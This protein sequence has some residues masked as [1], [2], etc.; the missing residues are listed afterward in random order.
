MQFVIEEFAVTN[1]E[2]ATVIAT[3]TTRL[4]KYNSAFLTL[5]AEHETDVVPA[6]NIDK[7]Y[8]LD[9]ILPTLG[10]KN[11]LTISL[12]KEFPVER[13]SDVFR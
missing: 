12:P 5:K 4:L 9:R 3:K 11:S 2:I 6:K 1:P 10:G 13:A 7:K 8:E